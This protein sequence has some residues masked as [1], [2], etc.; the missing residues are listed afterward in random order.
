MVELASGRALLR[1]P[2]AEN[3]RVGG[4]VPGKPL[5]W[6]VSGWGELWLWETKHWSLLTTTRF[7]GEGT[8]VTLGVGRAI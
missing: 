2:G 7:F 5:F 8:K 3:V 6:G 4:F 1:P